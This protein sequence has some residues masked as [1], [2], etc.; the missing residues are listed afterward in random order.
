MPLLVDVANVLHV[1]GVLPPEIAGPDEVALAELISRSR[2]GDHWVRL[3]CDGGAP[4]ERRPFP[5]LDISLIHTGRRSADEVI[6]EIASTSS[7]ARRIDVISN[8]RRVQ[9]GVRSFGCRIMRGEEFLER[10]ASDVSRRR[11]PQR[12]R[13]GSSGVDRSVPLAPE[14]VDAWL[15][16]FGMNDSPPRKEP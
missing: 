2:W 16:T 15:E 3:V 13:D 9:S 6:I 11:G 7:F 4:G 12:G 10:L 8:D 1:T 14:S 5:N